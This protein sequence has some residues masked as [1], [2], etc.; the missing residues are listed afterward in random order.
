MEIIKEK[1]K[2][3]TRLCQRYHEA[4]HGRR[5]EDIVARDTNLSR[6]P[7][8]RRDQ[9]PSDSISIKSAIVNP[10]LGMACDIHQRKRCVV[11]RSDAVL[12]ASLNTTRAP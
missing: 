5:L 1:R 6:H 3:V 8:N 4:V 11:Q 9:T 10:I 2:V 7:F 12:H